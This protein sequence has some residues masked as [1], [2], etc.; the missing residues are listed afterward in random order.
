[1]KSV[2]SFSN[3]DFQPDHIKPVLD[4]SMQYFHPS[5]PVHTNYIFINGNLEYKI[6]F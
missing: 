5:D 4:F 3:I 6:I 1:M 2:S